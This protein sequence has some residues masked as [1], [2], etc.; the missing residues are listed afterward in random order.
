MAWEDFTVIYFLFIFPGLCV[1]CK[2]AV[3]VKSPFRI[4]RGL[5]L[6]GFID[7]Y[8]A[9][10]LWARLLILIRIAKELHEAKR[11]QTGRPA[12]PAAVGCCWP[13]QHRTHKY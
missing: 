7:Q 2:I 12:S 13:L 4:Y 5:V 9:S 8:K 1:A 3:A 10:E 6:S 11:A